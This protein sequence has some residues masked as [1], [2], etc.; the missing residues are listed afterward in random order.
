M[1]EGCAFC[2]AARDEIAELRLALG[3]SGR[4][5]D[6]RLIERRFKLTRSEAKI[7]QALYDASGRVVP[8]STLETIALSEET[9]SN[10]LSVHICRLRGKIG[11]GCI[12]TAEHGYA[13][14]PTGRALVYTALKVKAVGEVA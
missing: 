13:M 1:A 12:D 3:L 9:Q 8:R 4:L 7:A 11:K 10:T 5:T 6:Q 14:T 2:M